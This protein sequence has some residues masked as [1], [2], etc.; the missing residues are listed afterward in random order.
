[1][2]VPLFNLVY[3]DA[4]IT[5][6][7][8]NDLRGFLN[9]GL[10]Q[11]RLSPDMSEQERLRIDRMRRLHERL[12]LTEL[13]NHEFLDGD[14]HRIERTTFSD[15][16]NVTVDWDKNGVTIEPELKE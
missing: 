13:M 9:G 12:A 2:P 6:Y 5:P 16:T 10:P 14:K 8:P 1:V 3:H 7:A 15:G 11:I 4:I